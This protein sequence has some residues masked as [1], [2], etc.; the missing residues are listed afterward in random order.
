MPKQTLKPPTSDNQNA[1]IAVRISSQLLDGLDN[2]RRLEDDLPSRAEM[3]RRLITR[4]T[5][6]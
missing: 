3:I 2:L 4:G 1:Q 6:G 5:N